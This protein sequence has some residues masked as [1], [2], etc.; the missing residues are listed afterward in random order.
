[1]NRD[2]L[3]GK[4]GWRKS[5]RNGKGKP[6]EKGKR[7]LGKKKVP[8]LVETNGGTYEN[9]AITYF[10][11]ATIIGDACLTTVFGMGTGMA[12]HL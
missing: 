9:P 8:P 2:G 3:A 11:V 12:R 7:A 5:L 10:R 4:P 1:M 6:T